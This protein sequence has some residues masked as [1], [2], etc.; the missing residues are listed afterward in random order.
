MFPMKK[1]QGT[2]LWQILVGSNQIYFIK[3]TR[4]RFEKQKKIG[5]GGGVT[6]PHTP[7]RYTPG[8]TGVRS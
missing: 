3:R 2:S 4:G 6:P 7:A 5:G 1:V 8:D